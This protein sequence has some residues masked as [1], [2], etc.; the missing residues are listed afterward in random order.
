[1]PHFVDQDKVKSGAFLY[2][3]IDSSPTNCIAS[4]QV[5]GSAV[6]ELTGAWTFL[7]KLRT[8]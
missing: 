3:A 1:M 5:L 6:I 7:R 2:S 4:S 8:A